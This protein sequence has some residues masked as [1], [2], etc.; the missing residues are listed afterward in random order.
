MKMRDALNLPFDRVMS[1]EI[2]RDQFYL[3]AKEAIAERDQ[4]RAKLEL[5]RELSRIEAEILRKTA[6]KYLTVERAMESLKC[7]EYEGCL[8]TACV[9]WLISSAHKMNSTRSVVEQDGVVVAGEEIG[10]WRVTVE[11]IDAPAKEMKD[12]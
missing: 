5:E 1:S 11:R 9:L 3:Q 10:K 8:W 7:G 2:L 6:V 12:E 4:L